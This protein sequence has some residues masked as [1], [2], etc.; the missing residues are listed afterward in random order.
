MSKKRN[1]AEENK[2]YEPVKEDEFD[3]KGRV[4]EYGG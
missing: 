1:G 4:N 2:K 3:N